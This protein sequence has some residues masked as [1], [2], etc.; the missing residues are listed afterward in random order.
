MGWNSWNTFGRDIHEQLFR[1]VADTLVNSGLR[2]LG[3]QYLCIDDFWQGERAAD[4]RPQP[5][6]AKFPSGVRALADYV[7]ARGLKLG[8][9]SDAGDLTCGGVFGSLGYEEIDAQTYAEWEVDYLKYDY[10]HA[11]GDRA[12]ATKRYTK[13]GKAL[14]ATGRPIVYSVCEWGGRQPWLWAAQAGGHLWRTTG[15]M[16]DS[17]YDH[18]RGDRNGIDHIGFDLQRGLERFVGPGRWNDPDM[19]VVGM[20][21]KGN[22]ADGSGCTHDEYR[23]Q[24]SLWCL[25]AAPL[26]I[27][28]DVRN[29]DVTAMEIVSNAEVIALDQDEL[30]AQGYNVA[31]FV[32]TEVYKK[33][34]MFGDLGVGV[35]NRDHH[36]PW[37]IRLDWSDL[38]IHGKYVVRDLW[39]HETLGVF[40]EKDHLMVETAP[41]A[42]HIFRF[43]PVEE[44]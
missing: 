12:T 38:E 42:C 31:N 30:G 39:K 10:C 3:Y 17:W 8:I 4:G 29:L 16:W 27:G 24:F 26:M 37:E 22:T 43:S 32:R 6:P 36:G 7:H 34:L 13:M 9:Y 11:P 40:D 15:D 23:T 25:L 14:R 19:L 33:P 21:G 5:E 41:H 20:H 35:F 1:E 2:D 44:E 28:S 18:A